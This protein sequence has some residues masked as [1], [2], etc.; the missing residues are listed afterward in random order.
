MDVEM[1]SAVISE[2][3]VSFVHPDGRK[4]AGRIWISDEFGQKDWAARLARLLKESSV[5][6]DEFADRISPR[7]T[8]E[9]NAPC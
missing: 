1:S 2:L 9:R 8:N 3:S 7:L 5:F 6:P 4:V